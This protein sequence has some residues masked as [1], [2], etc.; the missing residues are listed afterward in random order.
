[1]YLTG[2]Y[3]QTK[4]LKDTLESLTI[5]RRRSSDFYLEIKIG[6]EKKTLR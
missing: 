5:I 1:M 4:V 3:I 2:T 6:T